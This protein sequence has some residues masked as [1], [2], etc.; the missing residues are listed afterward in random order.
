MK[1][2]P[3]LAL[4]FLAVAPQMV[5]AQEWTRFRGENGAGVNDKATL[6]PSTFTE[7]DYKWK[8]ELPG[9]GTSSPVLWGTKL[10]LTAEGTADGDRSVICYDSATGKQLW[11]HSD[12]FKPHGHHK[13][14]NFASSTPTV[15]AKRVYI[16][17]TSGDEMRVLALTHDGKK[18]WEANLGYFQEEHGSGA[19][20]IVVGNRLIVCKDHSK[21]DA[22]IAGLNVDDGKT[23]WTL[24]RKTLRSAFSTPLVVEDKPGHKII[25]LN[26]NPNAM[27]A[28]DPATGKE[29]WQQDYEGK[30]TEYRAVASPCYTDGIYFATVGQGIGGRDGYALKIVGNKAETA[31]EMPKGIPYVP[32]P[33][34]MKGLIYILNDGG[35]MSCVKAATGEVLYNERVLENAYSSPVCAADRIIC[36]SR[37]GTVT[38]LKAGEKFEVLG[39]SSLGESCDSTPA[40]ANGTLFIRTSKHLIALGGSEPQASNYFKGRGVDVRFVS[41]VEQVQAGQPFTVGFQLKHQPGYHTYWKNPGLAGVEFRVDWTLPE[42]WKAGEIQWPAP[43]KIYMASILTHGYERDVMPLVTITPPADASGNV[44]LK[45]KAAWMACAQTCNPGFTD[46]EL[47]LPVAQ[48]PAVVS[49]EW[50]QA[51]ETSRSQEPIPCEGWNFTATREGDF[52]RLTGT[53]NSPKANAAKPEKDPIFFSDNKLICSDPKQTWTWSGAQF[54]AK[55]PL[56]DYAPKEAL[57]LSGVLYSPGGWMVDN[58]RSTNVY[59]SI[60]LSTAVGQ[61]NAAK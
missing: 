39:K 56:A 7:K 5:R 41:D 43:D 38:V 26:S 19:S 59:V 57:P 31:W 1:F 37:T 23:V 12:A 4:A 18:A 55:L 50:H 46:L 29:V 60:P 11:Q 21:Q 22:F 10:F 25:V 48:S 52:V 17:W 53:P 61:I 14:N 34:G 54:T 47:Q 49:N 58:A 40:I 8:I 15:D 45:A 20:P 6:I 30:Q 35:L 51:I 42:G 32:S 16:A 33:L 44:T 36:I 27:T 3:S 9:A 2:H 13:F 24:P 28:I